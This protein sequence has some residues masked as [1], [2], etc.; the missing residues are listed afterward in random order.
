MLAIR[1]NAFAQLGDRNR[2]DNTVAGHAPAFT[3]TGSDSQSPSIHRVQGTFMVPCY[4]TR[5]SW[6]AC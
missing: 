2:A 1:N 6:G 5:S 3:V 4:P